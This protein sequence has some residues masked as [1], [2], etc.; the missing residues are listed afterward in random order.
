MAINPRMQLS[1]ARVM[2]E[3]CRRMAEAET[4]PEVAGY[5]QGLAESFEGEVARL[6]AAVSDAQ[7]RRGRRPCA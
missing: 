6:A 3:R 5:L 2:A 4:R 1:H 7:P